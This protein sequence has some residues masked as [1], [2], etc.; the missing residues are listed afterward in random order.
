MATIARL[1]RPRGGAAEHRRGG[2]QKGSDKGDPGKLRSRQRDDVKMKFIVRQNGG[3][4]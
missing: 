4:W 3:L 1:W 2:A